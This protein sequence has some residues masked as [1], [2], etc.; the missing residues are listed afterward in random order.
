MLTFFLYFW[1][2]LATNVVLHRTVRLDSKIHSENAFFH[3]PF[4]RQQNFTTTT[5][6]LSSLTCIDFAA[7][8]SSRAVRVF[9]RAVRVARRAVHVFSRTVR[10][11]SRVV[12]VYSRAE[13][14]SSWVVRISSTTRSYSDLDCS[15]SPIF[16]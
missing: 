12:R 4:W 15:Q 6:F 10:I 2:S 13:R 7:R 8:V 5:L 9:S 1:S 11:C 3:Y 14:I 16:R